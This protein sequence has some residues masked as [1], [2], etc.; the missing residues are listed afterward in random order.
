MIIDYKLQNPNGITCYNDKGQAVGKI[1]L[2]TGQNKIDDKLWA[3][4][5][6]NLSSYHLQHIT[7]IEEVKEVVIEVKKEVE[8][9]KKIEVINDEVKSKKK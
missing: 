7:E 4:A 2:L 8:K 6:K 3:M 9:P 1:I 5:K